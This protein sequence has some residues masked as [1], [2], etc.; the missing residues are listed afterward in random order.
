MLD[1]AR[2]DP[3]GDTGDRLAQRDA[4]LGTAA[5]LCRG[6]LRRSRAGCMYTP[7]EREDVNLANSAIASKSLSFSF[8]SLFLLSAFS[9]STAAMRAA[10]RRSR[11]ALRAGRLPP[12]L[13]RP[14]I[15]AV[16]AGESLTGAASRGTTESRE[17][18]TLNL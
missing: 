2:V 15:Y 18:E 4:I 16:E 1:V 5:I 17:S 9:S 14:L 11:S 13:A 8:A 10:S 6:G 3:V 12:P 7:P